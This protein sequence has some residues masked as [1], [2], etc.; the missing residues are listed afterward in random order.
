MMDTVNMNTTTENGLEI[1]EASEE[2]TDVV[3]SVPTETGKKPDYEY[4]YVYYDE[5]GNTVEKSPPKSELNKVPDTV[6]LATAPNPALPNPSVTGQ[7]G[8]TPTIYA[9]LDGTEE[10]DKAT[11]DEIGRAHV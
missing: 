9:S 8:D 3:D 5:N 4:Y 11:E 10:T 2:D 6:V 1:K 7:T